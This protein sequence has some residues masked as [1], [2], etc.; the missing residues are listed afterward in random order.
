MRLLRLS[1]KEIRKKKF[2]SFLI[3]LV[4]VIAMQTVLSAITNATSAAYQQKIFENNMGVDMEQVLH[5]D[6]QYTEESPEFANVIRQYLDYIKE[7]PGVQAVGQFDATGMY[8]SELENMDEYRAINGELLKGQKYEDYPGISQLLSIDE[9]IL[10]FV[11][12]G[13]TEYAATTSGLLPLYVS[14]VFKDILSEGQ[15]LTDKRT[16]DQYEIVGYIPTGAKWVEEDDLIRFPLVSLDGWFIAPFT[17]QSRNDIMTQLSSLHNTYIFLSDSADINFLKEQISTYPLQH[18]FEVSAMLLSEEYKVYQS[19]T[20]TF[21]TRQ[22]ILAIFISIMAISSVVAVFTTNTLLKKKQYGIWIANGFT[23]SD[24]ATEI[25]IEIFIIIFCS[26]IFAWGMKWIEFAQS[27]DLFKT[28]LLTAHIRYTLPICIVLT[29]V[30]TGIAA[31]IPITKLLKYQP[32]EL[33]GGDT[34]GND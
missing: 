1:I 29:F 21:T 14:E 20:A 19:E 28:V 33:I 26:G 25:A 12:G 9:E 6:Y 8:F 32:C 2:F 10:S 31:L 30:L 13:I 3:L 27:T 5:L 7:L 34:N 11:K 16:G 17:E 23:L 18:G 24:I 4:C 15:I 22:M